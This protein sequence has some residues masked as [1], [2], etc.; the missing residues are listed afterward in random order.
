MASNRTTI[1]TQE[2][3]EKVQQALQDEKAFQEYK[4][5]IEAARARRKEKQNNADGARSV[6]NDLCSACTTQRYH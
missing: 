1:V 5:R 2:A 6:S 3:F 4:R